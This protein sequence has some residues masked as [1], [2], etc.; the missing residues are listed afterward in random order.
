MAASGIAASSET[1]SPVIGFIIGASSCGP[2]L[3]C[4]LQGRGGT[5]RFEKTRPPAIWGVN[6]DCRQLQGLPLEPC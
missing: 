4:P 2:A 3:K 5:G 6:M 1:A